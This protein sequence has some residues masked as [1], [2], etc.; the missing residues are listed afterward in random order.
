MA[1]DICGKTGTRLIELLS[2]YQTDSIK[3]ICHECTETVE[4][5]LAKIKQIQFRM[6]QS[7]FRRFLAMLRVKKMKEQP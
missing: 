6:T 7:L 5:H 3:C 2:D 1:C 4:D